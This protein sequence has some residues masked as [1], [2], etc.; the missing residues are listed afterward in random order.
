[1][2]R[3]ADKGYLT[4][5][6]PELTVSGGAGA[7]VDLAYAEILY[8]RKNVG[9]R[10]DVERKQFYGPADT[11]LADGGAHRTYRPLFWRTYRYLKLRVK[12]TDQP[13][14]IEDFHGTFTAFPFKKKAQFEVG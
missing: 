3:L 8:V 4:T 1:M 10:N 5:A 14:A 2:R 13:L 6:Y 9:N 12:T 11:N 7:S